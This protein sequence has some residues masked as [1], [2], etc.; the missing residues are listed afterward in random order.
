MLGPAASTASGS[1]RWVRVVIALAIWSVS[2][3]TV[4]L[5]VACAVASAVDAGELVGLSNGWGPGLVLVAL[6]ALWVLLLP[7]SLGGAAT[8][9]LLVR[10]VVGP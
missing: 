2:C 3:L 1:G 7:V 4:L 5:G 8:W 9:A 6:A 10:R